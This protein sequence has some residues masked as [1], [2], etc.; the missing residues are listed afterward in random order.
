MTS[1]NT[2]RFTPLLKGVDTKRSEV[3]GDFMNKKETILVTGAAGFIG[4][5]TAK[6]LLE[7]GKKIIGVDN[8]NDYY[9]VRLKKE[10]LKLLKHKNFTFI[11]LDFANKKQFFSK[12]KKHK[13]DKIIHLGAQAGVRYSIENPYAY[14]ESNILG[15][16]NIFE[17]AKQNKIKQVVYASSSSVYGLN[18]V[19]PFEE[20]HQTESQISVYAATKKSCE[21]LAHS[22]SHLFGV[23]MIGLRFFTVY[24]PWGRPDMALFKFSK[25]IL[26][27]KE[28]QVYNNGDMS[29]SFTYI[30]DIVDGVVASL[31][32]DKK[33]EIYNLGG[34][35]VV[36]L[37]DFIN[38][39]EIAFGVK[40][41]IKMLGMQAGDMKDTVAST[42]KAEQD[43]GYKAKTNIHDGMQKFAAWFLQ[44]RKLLLNL[45]Q[46]KQ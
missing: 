10:R 43:L 34:S 11:K 29:R 22:Y 13:I 9:D 30:D 5:H 31:N 26:Q 19:Q 39:I 21:A 4:F 20:H 24:G 8:L 36:R 38:E 40:A 45:K 16:L 27:G 6:K 35:E 42:K 3:T 41:K 2:N 33:Y 1:Q 18:E 25:N 14:I 17:Y 32:V 7:M 15:T 28:I 46:G 37:M 23:N 44:N 12:L